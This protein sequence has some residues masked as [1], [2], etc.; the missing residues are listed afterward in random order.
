MR[1]RH[2]QGYEEYEAGCIRRKQ[3][4]GDRR[5]AM[6]ILWRSFPP[7]CAKRQDSNPLSHGQWLSSRVLIGVVRVRGPQTLLETYKKA[8]TAYIQR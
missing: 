3:T 5:G 2:R 4:R 8:G 6:I 1:D 7:G